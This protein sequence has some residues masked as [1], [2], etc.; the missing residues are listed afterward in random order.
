MKQAANFADEC[1]SYYATYD[2]S[3]DFYSL[4][5]DDLPDFVQQEFAALIMADESSYATEATG[6]DNEHWSDEMLPALLTHLKDST[7]KE[8]AIEFTKVW[9]D[10]VTAYCKNKM[11]GLI[12]D[13]LIDYN[14]DFGYTRSSNHNYGVPLNEPF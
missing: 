7:D 13:A 8:K 2:N 14:S 9:R 10:C 12:D 4:E 5:V 1:V 3:D 11:Q 6:P